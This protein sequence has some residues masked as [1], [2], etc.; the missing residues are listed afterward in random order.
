[1]E[2]DLLL[3]NTVAFSFLVAILLLAWRFLNWAWFTPKRL[4]KCLRQQGFAGHP[5]RFMVGDVKDSALML[6]EAMSKPIPFNNDIVSRII[7]HIDTTIKTYGINSF[8]WMGRI[9]RI[10]VMESELIKEV[11]TYANKFQKNFDVHNPLAKFLLTGVGSFEGDKWSRHRRII[12]PAFT[13]DKLKTMLPA[14]AICYDDLLNKWANVATSEGSITVDV[15]PTFDTLTSDVIS[16]VA[17]GSTYDEG[18]RIFQLLKELMELTIQVIRDVYIP[19]WSYLPTKR[20]QRMKKI[21]KEMKDML[22]DIINKR[23]KAMKAG[24]P[25]EDDLLGILLESNFEEIERQGNKVNVGMTIDDVIE[26]CKLFYFAGQETT[27]ILLTWTIIL[28]SKHP[29]WQQRARDEVLQTFGNNKP[30]FEKLNHLK[31]VSMILYEVLRLYPPVIDLTKIVHDEMKLG[32]YSIPAGVQVMLPTVMIH[33]DKKVWGQD[34]LEFN[35]MRFADG[36]A[37]A[38]KNQV[39][40]IPFS[41]GPRVCLGQNF[42]LLQAKLGLAMILQRF[43]FELSSSYAHAPFTVL[44]LQPQYGSHAIFRKL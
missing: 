43:S 44:T 15:F 7:P 23:V 5:Y 27:G 36:V 1:M 42:A 35:P 34:A 11:L 37:K 31:Y 28:L 40:Y 14:F 30:D 26:E 33:R 21:N 2:S 20:N 16:K 38:T 18:G 4:E 32:N 12:A 8:T 22:R 24:E 9:P 25:Y 10:H 39:T 17:F 13:L 41:W 6:Q 29:E 19:G 3:G